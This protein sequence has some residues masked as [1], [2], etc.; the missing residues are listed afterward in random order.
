MTEMPNNVLLNDFVSQWDQIR[1]RALAAVNRVG[2]S[3]WL[4]LGQEVAQFEKSL[5]EWIQVKHVVGCANGL[6]AIENRIALSRS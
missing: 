6:D 3:G 4:I 2:E 5:S 1:D